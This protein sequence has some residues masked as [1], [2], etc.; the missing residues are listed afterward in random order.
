MTR[1][2][3]FVS[4]LQQQVIEISIAITNLSNLKKQKNLCLEPGRVK[5]I[6]YTCLGDSA[7]LIRCDEPADINGKLIVSSLK[8]FVKSLTFP[9]IS[10]ATE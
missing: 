10:I 4:E 2:T 8:N 1:Q 9:I 5:N 3:Q 6:R 7:Y